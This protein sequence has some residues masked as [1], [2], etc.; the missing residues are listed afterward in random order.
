MRL[1][2]F[3]GFAVLVCHEAGASGEESGPVRLNGIWGESVTFSP[4]IPSGSRVDS[5][6]WNAK[7]TIAIVKPGKEAAPQVT[8]QRYRERLRVLDGGYSLQIMDLSQ[9]DTGTYT[10]QITIEGTTEPI[11]QRFALHVYKRLTESDINIVPGQD[12]VRTVNGTCN[13]TLNCSL[14]GGGEDV[15]YTWTQTA[16]SSVVSSGA[17]ILISHR[18]GREVSPVTCTATNP[19]SNSSKSIFPQEVCEADLSTWRPT[20]VATETGITKSSALGLAAGT[21]GGIV[22]VASVLTAARLVRQRRKRESQRLN[23][24]LRD[25][26]ADAE[27]NTVYAKVGN[28][29]LACSRTGTQK[30]GPETKEDE[31]KTIYSKVHHPNQSPP[32]T[33][34]EKLCKEG[35]ESM[36]KGEKTIYATV[37]QPN[38]TKTAKSTDADDSAATPKPQATTE[39]DKII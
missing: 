21:C 16:E 20:T 1:P 23:P 27:T 33:D 28:L 6:V 2:W 24:E 9:E 35:L 34:D 13:V 36:E 5:I 11:F 30:R 29:P 8:D 39:Y 12:S 10:A 17:S 7:S 4:V 26:E 15:T 18:L 38:P 25:L 19:I 22:A 31:T 14:P 37:N 32:Q 3:W